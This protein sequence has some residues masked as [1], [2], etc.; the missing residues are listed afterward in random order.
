VYG[1][2]NK[3]INRKGWDGKKENDKYIIPEERGGND[4][5]KYF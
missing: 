2:N 5:G 1:F 3:Q 4:R